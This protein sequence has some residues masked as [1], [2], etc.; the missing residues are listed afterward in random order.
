MVVA[1]TESSLEGVSVLTELSVSVSMTV[2]SAKRASV[3]SAGVADIG[4]TLV[5]PVVVVVVMDVWV[6]ESVWSPG[7]I[8]SSVN[9]RVVVIESLNVT[10]LEVSM[11]PNSIVLVVSVFLGWSP[12]GTLSLV[13]ISVTRGGSTSDAKSSSE[14]FHLILEFKN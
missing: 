6:L 10:W 5:V 1:N 14:S 11:S 2:S 4:I 9:L 12:T 13:T 8:I 7:E 3:T